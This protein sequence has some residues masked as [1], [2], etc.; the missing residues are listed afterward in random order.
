MRSGHD[1]RSAIQCHAEIVAIAKLGYAGVQPNA[2]L[3]RYWI[4]GIRRRLGSRSARLGPLQRPLRCEARCK[5]IPSAHSYS[6]MLT[7]EGS[8]KPSELVMLG[9]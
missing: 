6:R 4:A 8:A 5:S 2:D 3:E 7:Y 1:S 9:T